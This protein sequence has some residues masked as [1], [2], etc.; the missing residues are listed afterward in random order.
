MRKQNQ[1][2]AL[3][4]KRILL[5]EDDEPTLES[6]VFKLEKSGFLTDFAADGISA[7]EKLS[8]DQSFDAI[9]LDL[10]LPR[11]DGFAFLKK[12]NED[13]AIKD[14]PVVIFTNLSQPEYVRRALDLG[15]KGY[16]VKAH[17]SLQEI[18]DELKKCM[19][20]A[21]CRVDY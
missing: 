14:I 13:P 17:H 18:V 3:A 12:K 10:R 15:A 8:K 6:A 11:G 19:E 1:K 5:V 21:E 4:R 2:I 9:L 7:L 16:L 20:G